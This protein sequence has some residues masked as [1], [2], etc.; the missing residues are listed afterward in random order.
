MSTP[1][2]PPPTPD[3][4]TLAA[5]VGDRPFAFV[6]GWPIAQSRSPALQGY[7]MRLRKISGAYTRLAVAPGGAALR[8]AIEF[9]RRT[10]NARGCNLTLPH[11]VDVLAMLDSVDP[12]ARRIGAVN[13]VV[14]Q[15]DGSLRGSN[16]DAFGFLE[17]LRQS[18]PGWKPGSGPV[19]VI[20]AGGAARAVIVALLDAGVPEL[21]LTNRTRATAIDLG[22]MLAPTDGRQ[23]A[24]V[25][26]AER[27]EMLDGTTLLVNTTSLG[28]AGH[29]PLELAL[30]RLPRT[31]VV[32]DI[33]YV[34]LETDL[35][36]RARAR[37]NPCVDGLGMLLHQGRPQFRAWFGGALPRVTPA[38][39]KAVAGDLGA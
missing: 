9:V 3:L 23:L 25:P 27:A 22:T 35:L 24:V 39:R 32:D 34:P 17:H 37:G 16:T 18:A 5:E 26:W 7:W 12:A 13:T 2:A 10:A 28:M 38:L 21:R 6:V 8:Q 20:G 33:V 15:P 11:K 19:A 1:A 36:R 29:E 31:A 4:A 14:K 30:D